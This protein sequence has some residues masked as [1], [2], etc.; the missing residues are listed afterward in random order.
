[1]QAI[2]QAR[3]FDRDRGDRNPFFRYQ[4]LERLGNLVTTR[5]NVYAVWI[6][7]GYFEVRRTE[8][9]A[10]NPQV[11]PDGWELGQELGLAEGVHDPL[12]RGKLITAPGIPDQGPAW[13]KGFPVETP[14]PA[15][16]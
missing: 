7:V 12:R 11:F 15:P 5:S 6:T 9:S 14:H 8:Y 10:G 4:G 13:A 3:G 1:L 16:S 2:Q